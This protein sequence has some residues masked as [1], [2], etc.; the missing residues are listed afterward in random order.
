MDYLGPL[1][2]YPTPSRKTSTLEKVHIVLFTCA[3]TRAIHLDIV[4][5]NT[6]EAFAN[7]LRRFISRRCIP[8]LV[9]S[10]NAKCFIG[11]ESRNFITTHDIEW[12][13]IL[14]VSPWWG[15]FYE[16]MV[17]VV[18][19]SLRKILRRANVTYDELLT[20]VTEIEAIVNCR[21]LCYLYTD[22]IDQELTA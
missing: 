3:N 1:F 12:S 17:Q 2:V 8:K 13:F 11:P 19:G 10:D 20:I 7:C 9:I 18:N 21:P 16:R 15:G 22:D 4:S 5:D 14:E 6:S